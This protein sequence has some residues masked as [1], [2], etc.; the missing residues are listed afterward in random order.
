MSICSM[1]DQTLAS[2]IMQD[3]FGQYICVTQSCNVRKRVPDAVYQPQKQN[4]RIGRKLFVYSKMLRY[5][6]HS[7]NWAHLQV[8]RSRPLFVTLSKKQA[9]AKK[10]VKHI[11]VLTDCEMKYRLV[12]RT[13]EGKSRDKRMNRQNT[14]RGKEINAVPGNSNDPPDD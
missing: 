1:D 6:W 11:Y 5:I 12:Y 14:N 8:T 10:N 4:K 13:N 9:T 7:S 2:V 3:T